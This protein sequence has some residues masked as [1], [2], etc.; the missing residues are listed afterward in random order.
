MTENQLLGIMRYMKRLFI[1]ILALI[2][3]GIYADSLE[4]ANGDT[5]T[6]SIIAM[7][8][9]TVTIQT[10]YGKLTV[11]RTYVSGLFLENQKSDFAA[12]GIVFEYLF[13]ESLQ[14]SSSNKLNG[15]NNGLS[16]VYGFDG[17]TNSAINS[18]GNGTFG[19]IKNTSQLSDL[20]SFT[21]EFMVKPVQV[22]KTQYLISKWTNTDGDKAVG[23]FALS[24]SRGALVLYLTESPSGDGGPGDDEVPQ[25]GQR[26]VSAVLRNALTVN[27]WQHVAITYLGGFVRFYV[28]G[29]LKSEQNTGINGLGHDDSP[30]YIMTAAKGEDMK[31]YNFIGYMDNLRMYNRSLDES[32]IQLITSEAP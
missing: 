2:T 7:D 29:V 22:N 20:S 6:G 5:I 19:V 27:E 21:I 17:S 15:E 23:S 26:Y 12:E 18:T 4:M 31:A 25:E 14:D 3:A 32:E 8:L 16:F 28:D 10:V 30:L 11:D 13:N 9:E 24:Y 1:F